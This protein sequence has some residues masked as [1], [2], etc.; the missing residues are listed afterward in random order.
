MALKPDRH[1]LDTRIDYFMNEV[2]TRG[3]GVVLSTS[4]SGVANDQSVSVAT[5]S[6]SVSGKIPLGILLCD[7][8]DKD[9]TKTHVNYYKEEVQKGTKVTIL[10]KGYVVTDML[11][12]GVSP[13]GG[14]PAYLNASGLF[15]PTLVANV[16]PL[17]GRFET[18]KDEDGFVK[19]SVNLP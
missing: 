13:V 14:N 19:I 4:G 15:T 12:P 6:N 7:M 2:A 9:L 17:V 18:A 10:T 11:V 1:L 3:G 5:Y 16:T 8:V